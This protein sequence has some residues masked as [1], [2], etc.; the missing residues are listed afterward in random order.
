MEPDI[1]SRLGLTVTSLLTVMAIMWSVTESLPISNDSTWI[2]D[3]SN[4]CTIIIGFC[5]LEN[6]MVA[7]FQSKA[8]TPPKWLKR[9]IDISNVFSR[10][11]DRVYLHFVDNCS[12]WFCDIYKVF[13]KVPKRRRCR[14]VNIELS[15]QS[16]SDVESNQVDVNNRKDSDD[17]CDNDD[18]N[19][20][21]NDNWKDDLN[22]DKRDTI[23]PTI[24]NP[25]QNVDDNPQIDNHHETVDENRH[26]ENRH[27]ENKH[28]D[29]SE[30][31]LK[32]IEKDVTWERFGRSFDRFMRVLLPFT[33]LVGF[34]HYF[35]RI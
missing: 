13:Y 24:I 32:K 26:D 25:L 27:D 30:T 3:F 17:E 14:S 21:D 4:F 29:S 5:C 2:Q 7:Y 19:N 33:L 22:P 8:G 1:N 31:L 18:N 6:A 34:I 23:T 9:F 12:D 28:E 15:Q 35:E 11:Y 10:I 16:V 20:N